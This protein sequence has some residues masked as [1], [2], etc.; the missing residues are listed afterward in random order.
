MLSVILGESASSRLYKNLIEK[1]KDRI[2]NMIDSE[3]YI[4]RDGG[5]FFI[6][7]NFIP[8]KKEEAIS[9]IKQ[10]IESIKTTITEDEVKKAKK[11]IKSRFASNAETVSEIGENIGYY[12]TVCNDLSLVSDYLGIVDEIGVEDIQA[13]AKE[14]LNIDNA[15]ISVLLPEE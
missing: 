7:A 2:F 12:M 13:T 10:E 11:K 6:Q 9:L 4:F 8:E 15:V 5:N 1:Q 14:F 3:H